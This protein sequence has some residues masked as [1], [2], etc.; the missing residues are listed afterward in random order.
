MFSFLFEGTF[1]SFSPFPPPLLPSPFSFLSSF[2][3]LPSFSPLFLQQKIMS[4]FH[5]GR[6]KLNLPERSYASEIS[7]PDTGKGQRSLLEPLRSIPR[8]RETLESKYIQL[9]YL[10]QDEAFRYEPTRESLK[11]DDLKEIFAF[12]EGAVEPFEKD[13]IEQLLQQWGSFTGQT[14][15]RKKERDRTSDNLRG[16]ARPFL[17]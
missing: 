16:L 2:P 13:V 10:C 5:Y 7:P 14:S 3:F 4:Y 17:N 12:E 15:Q 8:L 9:E 6:G 11:Q 1:S